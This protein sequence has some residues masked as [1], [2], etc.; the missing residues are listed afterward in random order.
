MLG[1][2]RAPQTWPAPI[3]RIREL[4]DDKGYIDGWFNGQRVKLYDTKTFF[5]AEPPDSGA[6]TGGQLGADAETAPRLGPIPTIYAIAAAGGI[7][8][9]LS[10]LSRAPPGPSV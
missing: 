3:T 7:P 6:S 5:C 10:T 2:A 1:M 8:R 9:R 4:T